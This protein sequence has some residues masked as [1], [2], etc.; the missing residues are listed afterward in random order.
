MSIGDHAFV[1]CGS[2]VP[3]ILRRAYLSLVAC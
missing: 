2:Q 3:F 1:L